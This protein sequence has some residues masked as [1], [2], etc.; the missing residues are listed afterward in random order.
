MGWCGCGQQGVSVAGVRSA[1]QV[2][3][4]GAA[5]CSVRWAALGLSAR[6]SSP[7]AWCLFRC[8]AH[9][10]H[11]FSTCRTRWLCWSSSPARLPACLTPVSLPAPVL[12]PDSLPLAGPGGSA[13]Q[14]V[15]ARRQGCRLQRAA[16]GQQQP[17]RC[18]TGMLLLVLRL[19]SC[20]GCY[21]QAGIW[22]C[23]PVPPIFRAS[24][25]HVPAPGLPVHLILPP[26]NLP[27]PLCR[28]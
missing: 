10:A 27:L 20:T 18:M 7:A 24:P 14:G 17:N 2:W 12:P 8:L 22:G 1:C 4:W 11:L 9:A 15:P 26:A 19:Y 3:E 5:G 16:G 6:L 23:P 25:L 28:C 21:M 13:G